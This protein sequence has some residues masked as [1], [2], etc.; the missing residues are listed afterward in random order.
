MKKLISVAA[1]MLALAMG[2]ICVGC[3]S[4]GG[5]PMYTH[6]RVYLRDEVVYN[7]KFDAMGFILN[8]D[9]GFYNAE[10]LSC[11]Y[12]NYSYWENGD[13]IV[14][15]NIRVDRYFLIK[16]KIQGKVYADQAISHFNG[17]EFV[18]RAVYYTSIAPG[19]RL[20]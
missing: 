7:D 5:G 13:H 10:S 6:V 17:L 19:I 14:D 4:P 15:E 1:V 11:F 18:D 12:Y 9:F 3:G 2:V 20:E 16:L 8:D